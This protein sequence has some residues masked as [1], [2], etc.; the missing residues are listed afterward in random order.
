MVR[1]DPELK[2]DPDISSGDITNN[3]FM[4]Q[5]FDLP[6]YYSNGYVLFSPG[7]K[8]ELSLTSCPTVTTGRENRPKLGKFLL[9][10]EQVTSLEY[11]PSIPVF[12]LKV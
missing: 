3:P 4:F 6:C 11:F 12:D 9:S 8:G 10:P 2:V 1:V 7:K 5:Y